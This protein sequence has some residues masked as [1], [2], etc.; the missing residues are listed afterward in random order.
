MCSA[1]CVIELLDELPEVSMRAG[2]SQRLVPSQ[3]Q[4][5]NA[6]EALG[7]LADISKLQPI[8]ETS[9]GFLYRTYCQAAVMITLDEMCPS[10]S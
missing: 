5:Q 1:V 3:E 4:T 6:R 10:V 8:P 9:A 2:S 7:W